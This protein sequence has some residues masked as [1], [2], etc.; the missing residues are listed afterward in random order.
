MSTPAAEN[1]TLRLIHRH[2]SIR[3][4][5]PAPLDTETV[6]AI[7]AAA[8]NTSTSSYSQSYTVITVTDPSRRRDMARLADD[9]EFVAEAGAFLVWC[10]DLNRHR[11]ACEKHGQAFHGEGL[12][13][14]LMA[15]V[16]TALAAQT[17]MLA[18]ESMGLGG[19]YV[20][21]IR[22]FATEVAA[23]LELPDYVYPV[24]GMALGY[25]DETPSSRPRLPLDAILHENSY[26]LEGLPAALETFDSVTADYYA[27]RSGGTRPATWTG[28]MARLFSQPRRP[29]LRSF[30]EA[31]GLL[32]R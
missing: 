1:E 14:F 24:F 15:S 19:V 6:R 9:Q 8:Q 31:R 20:G 7:V 5:R 26:R 2:R 28:R 22:Q 18:A 27:H 12:E 21:A 11:L 4:F 30:L 16:D 3:R 32:L 17:A 13:A 25:P 23:L 10:A 29:H